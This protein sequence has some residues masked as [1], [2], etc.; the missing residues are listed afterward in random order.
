MTAEPNWTEQ[1]DKS[2][3]LDPAER[4]EKMIDLMRKEIDF[5]TTNLRNLRA[6]NDR[7]QREMEALEQR[8]V[9]NRDQ[10]KQAE[11]GRLAAERFL[12]AKGIA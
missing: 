3:L 11:S 7:L 8:L 4:N 1:L 12:S 6:Q 10:T 2:Q 9:E 5:Q